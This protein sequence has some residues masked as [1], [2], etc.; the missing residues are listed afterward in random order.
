M[1]SHST[2]LG[3]DVG[4]VSICVA[5]MTLRKE[6]V[7]TAY[8]SHH[9]NIS[10]NL[11]KI[12]HTFDFSHICSIA[13]TSSTPSIIK[14]RTQYD[15]Q[16]C[17]ITAAKHLY[18]QIGSI[19]IVGGEK[20]GL[21]LFDEQGNYLNFKTNTSC[22]A[23][24]GSFLDQQA[25]R[26]N[27]NG[28]EELS[29][30]A[31][32]NKGKI[33]KIASR[34]A[35]F[36]KTDL[37]NAQQE[38]YL[39]DEISDGLC[40]G[41]AKNIID[42]IYKGK[43]LTAPV[44]FCGG[45]SKNRAVVRHV[46]SLIGID[47]IVDDMSHI[48]GALGAALSLIDEG[49]SEK[50][51]VERNPSDI[52]LHRREE[53]KF[54]YEPLTLKLSD[55]PDFTGLEKYNFQTR[56]GRS[57]EVD[58]YEKLQSTAHYKAYCGIDIGS[59]S[60]KAVLTDSSNVV[61]AGFYTRTAGS[62]LSAVRAL[63]EAIDDII[64]RKHIVITI[65]GAGTTGSGRK[66]IGKIIGAD[67]I[68]DEIT[69]HARAAYE[70]NPDVDTIFEIGGQDAKFTTLKNG[71]VTC[72]IMNNV[73]AAGT[74]SFI[75]EQAQ[76]LG[77]SL[78]DYSGRTEHVRAPITSDRCT[79]FMERDINHY[80]SEGYSINELLTSVLHSVRENYF[81]KVAV[82]S[83]I[84]D[85]I[86][87]QGATAKNKAL[88]AAFEQKLGK[89]IYVS[90]YCHLTGALGVTLILAEEGIS[91]TC[92]RGI[93]IYKNDIPLRSE[94]CDICTNH[95]KITVADIKGERV[96]YGFLCGRDYDTKKHINK[97]KAGFDLIS[98]RKKVSS[99]KLTKR[100]RENGTIGIP[101]ALYLFED[102]QFWRYF[103][104]L[105]SL[106]TVTSEEYLDSVKE[107]KNITGAEFCAPI[108]S[109]HGHA[110]YLLGKADYIFLP[111]YLENKRK[112]KGVRRHYCYYTQF[113]PTLVS[114]IGNGDKGTF[115]MPIVKY[116]YVSYHTKFQLYKMLKS[117]TTT[118]ISFFEVSTA[119]EK[120]FEFK[121]QCIQRLQTLYQSQLKKSN[122][123]SV[124]FIGRP[125]TILCPS[126]NNGI[127][128]IFSSLGVKTFYQDMLSYSEE[129]VASIKSLLD[130]FHWNYA[131][132]ILE[133]TE[134]VAKTHSVYPVLITSFKC[135]PDSFVIDHFKKIMESHEKPYLILQLDQYDS[136]VGY[137]TRIEAAIRAFRNHATSKRI[138]RPVT[139]H[140]IN[141]SFK[142]E[143][144]AKTIV[145]PNWDNI[146]C[147]FLVANL[148][149]EGF[150]ARLLEENSVT[151]QKS[152]RY[153]QGQCIPLSI[154]AQEYIECIEK[155]N[156]DPAKTV[157]WI[158]HSNISCNIKLYPHY[159]KSFL[160]SFGKGMENAGVYTGPISFLDISVTAAINAYFA[161]M[162]GGLVRKLGCKKRPYENEKG[163][164]DSV[165]KKSIDIL[166]Q[167]F[168]GNRS[169]EDVL[170][171]VIS[172]FEKIVTTEEK[173]PKVAIFGDIYVRDNEVINQDLIHFIEDNG[174][175]VITTPYNN[176]AKMIA[177]LYFRKWFTEG[178]Y[179]EV[180][181][182]KTLLATVMRMEKA[183]YK[184][185]E[186]VLHEPDFKFD[187]SPE[188][189]LSKYNIILEHTGESMDNILKIFYI[190]QHY[191]DISLFVQ[192]SPS[193][194]CPSLITEAMSQ[195]IEKITGIP[196]VTITYDGTGGNKNNTIIPYLKY[197]RNIDSLVSPSDN[198]LCPI[199]A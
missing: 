50:Q 188:T 173:R 174:G 17:V 129:D 111:F 124:M 35:V 196:V 55:Y 2:V 49:A 26:L 115:L 171:E 94:V 34:C 112:E 99:F 3:I 132:K 1:L 190:K 10:E 146:T 85:I 175:E 33:P 145:L 178:K 69:A 63:F 66:F 47:L 117:I 165:I 4:S 41:L 104:N 134:I 5:Q 79:V 21:I 179:L 16:I 140:S 81:M 189:I 64:Q 149:R 160:I 154:I 102:L 53:K 164:T 48:F 30:I 198:Y 77:V 98:E 169:K 86:A 12:L 56:E 40:Y 93:D 195:E 142:G 67:S 82:E 22:A 157:L 24:T 72:S 59:T 131:S 6:I 80:L 135:S 29:E 184:Y 76:K 176:Y 37:I 95:C 108:S 183:Y 9:G 39:I 128:D 168:L 193:F 152:L 105:L 120:A 90:K 8:A 57:V 197:P 87:F 170:A 138:R 45:V 126:L 88:V 130:Q 158:G 167:G 61:L 125:Y 11:I 52:I 113:I 194:C 84:G 103:F 38:G 32:R 68:I 51:R 83:G 31:F 116:L 75:E 147:N 18:T 136:R 89:P 191:P 107:G 97:N 181:I 110:H 148:R 186:K 159:I 161:F 71:V 166:S 182:S 137:E 143:L 36:A 151:I 119:Y 199:K 44:L 114:A 96:T 121:N 92:F 13:T 144:T 185:F 65:I 15:N 163:I 187:Q 74:G 150:D 54:Y 123:I 19:L 127:P 155:N 101:T 42:T 118:T 70:L 7:R 20:F 122:D 25:A 100:F 23:G 109:M 156:L 14:K 91:H 180:I 62:P 133:A 58:I 139:Y 60:T 28:V 153:N 141:F 46:S 162:F 192:T 177:R 73:C 106:K 27:L 78:T 172:Y 43:K